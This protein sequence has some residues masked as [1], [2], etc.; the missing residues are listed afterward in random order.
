MAKSL[1]LL[2]T[3]NVDSLGIVG[4]VV[5]VRT[6][7][8]RNFLLPR[9][10]AT[11]PSDD[12]VKELAG[13]R[14]E[15]EKQVAAQ[16]KAREELNE[17]LKGIEIT[18]IRS[19]NDMGILYGAITQQDVAAALK[20][21]GH[22]VKPRDV[23]IA[24]TIKRIDSYDVHVKLDSDLDS[25]IKLHV[26]PDRELDLEREPEA[27]GA[28][29][30]AESEERSAM[31]RQEAAEEAAKATRG[32]WGAGKP[33]ATDAKKTDEGRG[34]KPVKADRGDKAEKSDKGDKSD[35]AEKGDKAPKADKPEK[36]A[37]PEK[38]A[39][40]DADGGEKKGKKK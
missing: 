32:T 23:R 31:K 16:R 2:L 22:D 15:A 20:E 18:L 26:K 8:A 1:K 40:A 17:K 34:E 12:M 25:T 33:A 3:E 4:D 9:N 6:G 5:N 27:A 38:K 13:R 39:K 35:K 14:K 30:G 37:K 11:T 10:M 7:Y 36:A 29:A 19:T 24:Q 21:Q 28:G